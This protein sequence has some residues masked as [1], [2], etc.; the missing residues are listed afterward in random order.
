M[1]IY[2]PPNDTMGMEDLQV[3]WEACLVGII[4]IVLGDLNVNFRDP[5]DK[6]DELII[7]LLD[8]INRVDSLQ[9]FFL[10][11]HANN[12][13]RHGGPGGTRGMGGC[14]T[15]NQTIDLQGRWTLAFGG[16]NI[17]TRTTE[18]S[19]QPSEWGGSD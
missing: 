15:C 6:R 7:D 8:D 1:S 10:D 18:P 12:Q 3:A 5:R 9:K 14:T 4:P 2:I 16:R 19:S 13:S 11:D 17:T